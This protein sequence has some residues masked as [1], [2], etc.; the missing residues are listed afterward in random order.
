MRRR[1][2]REPRTAPMIRGVLDFGGWGDLL[3]WMRAEDRREKERVGVE[4][5]EGHGREWDDAKYD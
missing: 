3:H 5:V 1:K 2:R 4:E